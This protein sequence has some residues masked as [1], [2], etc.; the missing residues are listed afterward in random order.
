MKSVLLENVPPRIKI[1][2]DVP[3]PK[4]ILEAQL[5]FRLGLSP[6]QAHLK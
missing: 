6:V 4:I 5:S 3:G 2:T 1:L